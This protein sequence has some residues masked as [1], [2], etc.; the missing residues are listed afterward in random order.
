MLRSK[1]GTPVSA[2]LI[3]IVWERI[4]DLI[5]LVL[6][7]ALVLLNYTA[8][9]SQFLIPILA[10][11]SVI[12][13]VICFLFLAISYR[14]IGEVVLGVFTRLFH[15]TELQETFLTTFYNTEIGLAKISKCLV[16]AFLAW[17]LQASVL[18]LSLLSLGI[19]LPLPLVFG[20]F[21]LSYVVGLASMLPGGIGSVELATTVLLVAAGVQTQI[22]VAAVLISRLLTFWYAMLLGGISFITLSRGP[23]NDN[24]Q[25]A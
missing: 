11:V 15:K 8:I 12:V 25:V 17:A 5:V 21:G 13:G 16:F 22:A 18:Y 9:T 3:S 1:F 23:K 10:G 6:F 7:S 4:V 20:V 14:R 19:S 24:L 2:S